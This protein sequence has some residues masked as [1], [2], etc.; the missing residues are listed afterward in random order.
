MKTHNYLLFIYISG[1]FL[2]FPEITFCQKT[3]FSKLEIYAKTKNTAELKTALKEIDTAQLT[4]N[5]KGLWYYY[6]AR[7]HQYIDKQDIAYNYILKAKNIANKLNHKEQR[8]NC[9]LW[10]L[11]I[12]SHRSK[13]TIDSAPILTELESD[14]K[15]LNNNKAVREYYRRI[16][17][18]YLDAK[19]A[20][21]AIEYFNKTIPLIIKKE[22]S[23][24]IAYVYM[25][26][27]TVH[28]TVSTNPDSSLFY[29]KK[30]IFFLKKYKDL[31]TLAYNYNNQAQQYKLL[32][33]YDKA[34]EL[35]QKADSISL[36]ENINSSKLIFYKNLAETYELS[37][38]FKNATL[39]LNKITALKD[40]IN[41]TKQNIAISEINEKYNNEKLRADNLVIDA[42]RKKNKNLLFL[43]LALLFFGIITFV[44][45]QKNTKKKQRLA[46]KEKEL[47]TQKLS[48][49]LK[50]Q[51]LTMIDAMVAGQ[52]KERQRIAND[53]H[54]DL[55][56]LLANV[57]LHFDALKEKKSE[58]LFE[59]TH[60][61]IDETYDKVRSLSHAKN[62][63]V[64]AKQGLLKAVQNM[65]DKISQ[66]NKISIAVFDYELN[67][68]L[69]N[70]LEITLFRI[71]QE[72]I[73]NTLKHANASEIE[74]HLTNH[75]DTLNILFEDNGIGFDTAQ[76]LAKHNGMGLSSIDK[77]IEHL[78]GSM[79]IDS[80]KNQGT[81]FIIDIPL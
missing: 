12:L 78:N 43:S 26:I 44:L 5:D 6:F 14:A 59:R 18:Q 20:L 60:V 17:I 25:N 42:K 73:T 65:A 48:T 7:L 74:I 69:E 70:S 10:L 2:L 33:K 11:E 52:E 13:A 36:K 1:I 76:I 50:E 81:T 47:Q 49:V 23:V 66:T 79:N 77:R 32:K 61:L 72:L 30:A 56:S 62:S 63:G 54:D 3:N 24:R 9:N 28:S 35:Y 57:R 55:G 68:R 51:E 16:A 15:A 29:N 75:G 27:A 4:L 34:V 80:I 22:D 41:D 38:D 37:E 64:I 31:Q 58:D 8:L 21:K 45:I 53:L 39:Y 46:E 40:S 19:N 67:E 71:L